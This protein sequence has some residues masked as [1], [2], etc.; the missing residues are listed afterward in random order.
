MS[1][2]S[3]KVEKAKKKNQVLVDLLLFDHCEITHWVDLLKCKGPFSIQQL[4]EFGGVIKGMRVVGYLRTCILCMPLSPLLY[5]SIEPFVGLQ[6][7][8]NPLPD[9]V[10]GFGTLK[11]VVVTF[12]P[13]PQRL[14]LGLSKR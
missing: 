12:L 9:R 1:H 7:W 6:K 5:Y 13:V 10:Q 4:R 2:R 11:G 3:K 8:C 14:C